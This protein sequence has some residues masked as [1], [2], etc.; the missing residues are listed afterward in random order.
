MADLINGDGAPHSFDRQLDRINDT[1]AN[2]TAVMAVQRELAGHHHAL[3]E[4]RHE[5]VM[6]EIRELL[7]LQREHRIDIMALFLA[8]KETR[9]RSERL[10]PPR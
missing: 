2:L 1:L 9:E 4:K 7:I 10:E 8:S 3:A 6:E 5:L